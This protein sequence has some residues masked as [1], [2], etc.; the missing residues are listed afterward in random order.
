M[1]ETIDFGNFKWTHLLNPTEENL[2]Y[3]LDT[4]H[5]HPLDI[6][7]CKSKVQR[8]KIDIYDDYNFI[9]LHFPAY[10]KSNKFLKTK[11]IKLFWG[12][13]FLITIGNSHWVVRKQFT[14][15]QNNLD[16]FKKSL[17]SNTSDAVLYTILE[18]LMKDNFAIIDRI[19]HEVDQISL[20]L[21]S[22]KAEK[23][24]EKISITRKNIILLDTIFK[25]QLRL[26][27]K[28]ESGEI[29]G[30]A[31][32]MEEYWGNILDYYQKMWDMVEDNEELID[33]LSKTY[34]SLQSNKI[35]QIMKILTLISTIMLPMTFI[36]SLYGMNID[37]PFQFHPFAFFIV[38]GF[39]LGMV[40]FFL[41]VFIKKKWL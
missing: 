14:Q 13:D 3:L 1:I 7:D 6:E 38:S 18:A 10:D 41:W 16:E 32:D 11:E 37:L 29:K 2:E 26:F 19:S 39:M 15:I 17:S 31:E 4:Y 25:P 28:F 30:Y 23:I 36:A 40:I 24:I 12:K 20:D 35:N 22:K 9:I 8:P 33:G 21:F 5:F 27:H 34:D